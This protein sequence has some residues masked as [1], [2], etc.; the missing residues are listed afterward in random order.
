[1]ILLDINGRQ[2]NVST[3]R[4]LIKWDRVVS[5][6]QKAVKDFLRPYWQGDVVLEELRIPGSLSRC[7]LI[8]INHKVVVEVSPSQ[9]TQYHPFFHGSLAGFR[10][11]IKSDLRKQHWAE[12]NGFRFVEVLDEDINVLTPKWFLDK[13]GVVL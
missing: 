8:N 7:D 3:T 5:R 10:A 6:P 2:R 1:M 13:Y 9:H 12:M 4:Y 11:S